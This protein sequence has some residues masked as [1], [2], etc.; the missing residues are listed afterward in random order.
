MCNF[1]QSISSLQEFQFSL[2]AG[3][4]VTQESSSNSG[5]LWL[6]SSKV[7]KNEIWVKKKYIIQLSLN[8]LLFEECIVH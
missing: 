4:E 6:P 7:L 8:K 3:G 5:N 1:T 2:E